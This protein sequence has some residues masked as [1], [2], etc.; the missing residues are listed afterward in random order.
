MV[1][2]GIHWF[3]VGSIGSGS[4]P[5]ALGGIHWLWVRSIGSGWDPWLSIGSGWG[6]IGSG[7]DPWL[8]IG[9][10][11]DP[12]ALGGIHGCPLALDGDP[13]ALGWGPLVLGGIHWFWVGIHWLWVGSIGSGWDPWLSF[14]SGWGSIGSGWAPLSVPAVVVALRPVALRGVS[15]G[16]PVAQGGLR[17][18]FSPQVPGL[19]TRCA[20]TSSRRPG[21]RWRAMCSLCCPAWTRSVGRGGD[22]DDPHAA[23]TLTSC[24]TRCPRLGGLL[25]PRT[26][27]FHAEPVPGG[28]GAPHRLRGLC[29]EE[30]GADERG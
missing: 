21:R 20:A 9:S 28:A 27:P 1:L 26:P 17:P 8:S 25:A 19:G 3:W 4:D 11:W 13:M 23:P 5:S 12:S 18:P 24:P 30:L 22:G 14:G 6:S 10:G 29:V 2:G 16:R 15:P 7:W